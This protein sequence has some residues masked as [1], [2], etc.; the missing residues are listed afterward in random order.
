MHKLLFVGNVSLLAILVGCRGTG[1]PEFTAAGAHIA[2]TS[3]AGTVVAINIKA[4]NRFDDP[5]PLTRVDYTV[6]LDGK[7]AVAGVRSAQATAHR[8]SQQV[9]TLPAVAT[10]NI[11]PSSYRITG[12]VTYVPANLIERVFYDEG[13]YRPSESFTFEGSVDAMPPEAL[14]RRA[15]ELTGVKPR[16]AAAPDKSDSK[17]KPEPVPQVQPEPRKDDS[18]PQNVP[19]ETAPK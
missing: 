17:S 15:P 11:K 8:F 9:F 10:G 5:L 6:E 18:K 12:T 2:E 4:L 7:P 14:V 13:V 3:D 19:A 16:P 1:H